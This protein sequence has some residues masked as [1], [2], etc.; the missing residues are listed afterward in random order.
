MVKKEKATA[1]QETKKEEKKTTPEKPCEKARDAA[2]E[3]H[4]K[5]IDALKEDQAKLKVQIEKAQS[6]KDEYQSERTLMWEKLKA[7]DVDKKALKEKKDALLNH[8]KS[9]NEAKKSL[10]KLGREANTMNEEK[11]D[12][13]I[14]RLESKMTTT[15]MSLKETKLAMAEIKKFKA[16]RP[17]AAKK[18]QEFED[19]K[20]K[21]EAADVVPEGVDKETQLADVK[22][23]IKKLTEEHNKQYTEIT[24]HQG[25]RSEKMEGSKE[26]IDKKTALREQ[27]NEIVAKKDAIWTEYKEKSK[28]F[29]VWEKEQRMER[30]K[31]QQAV[32]EAEKAVWAAKDAE[33]ELEQPS[34]YIEKFIKVDQAI[35]FCKDLLPKAKEEETVAEKKELTQ[36]VEGATILCKKSDRDAFFS[37]VPKKKNLRKQNTKV[38]SNAIKHTG[39][40]LSTFKD[41]GV[42]A[43]VTTLELPATLELLEVQLKDLEEKTAAWETDRKAK[44]AE[45]LANK[46]ATEEAAEEPAMA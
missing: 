41:L 45:A 44:I 38:K 30:M 25:K 19:Q 2:I 4:K 22:E 24:A 34:P 9:Q 12:E 1:P 8:F 14:R 46:P 33:R 35:Q 3:V 36:L 40:T 15:T 10:S 21:N 26:L 20:A 16:Q 28:L 29:N 17:E 37:V 27:I 18:A 5:E 11:I 7:I 31:K 43:P 6:G 13:A 39:D 42:V 32:W 23:A